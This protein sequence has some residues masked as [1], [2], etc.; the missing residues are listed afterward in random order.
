[1]SDDPATDAPTPERTG[2]YCTDCGHQVASFDGLNACPACGS[3]ALPC[4]W[5]DEVSVTV[6]WHALRVL[7]IW[8]ENW[9]R[10]R[11]LGR[12]VY[13]IAGRIRAQHPDRIPLTLAEELGEVA[14]QY[15]GMAVNDPRLRQDIA[16]QTGREVD[17][18]SG[19]DPEVTP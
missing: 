3:T 10:E 1:M 8:A 15:P 6:N 12:A 5:A 13:A 14:G 11:K 17:L 7:I 9:Q 4:A 18:I 16:E 2:G 19:T